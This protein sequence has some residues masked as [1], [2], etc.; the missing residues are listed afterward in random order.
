MQ[1]LRITDNGRQHSEISTHANDNKIVAATKYLLGINEFSQVMPTLKNRQWKQFGLNL[2][3]GGMKFGLSTISLATMTY[4]LGKSISSFVTSSNLKENEIDDL[5]RAVRRDSEQI[6]LKKERFVPELSKGSRKEDVN[7]KEKEWDDLMHPIE[8]DRDQ[9]KLKKERFV[10][11]LFKGSLKT[12]E[13]NNDLQNV[14][15]GLLGNFTMNST[16][17]NLFPQTQQDLPD[18]EKERNTKLKETKEILEKLQEKTKENKNRNFSEVLEEKLQTVKGER[19]A[20]ELKLESEFKQFLKDRVPEKMESYLKEITDDNIRQNL[21]EF[22]DV[23]NDQNDFDQKI[24][25]QL[26]SRKQQ[27]SY[28]FQYIEQVPEVFLDSMLKLIRIYDEAILEWGNHLSG[29]DSLS[30]LTTVKRKWI[31]QKFKAEKV[32]KHIKIANDQIRSNAQ[33]NTISKIKIVGAAIAVS[34]LSLSFYLSGCF[35]VH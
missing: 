7:I 15:H 12:E 13:N 21:R 10:S 25:S 6:K 34:C 19:E 8:R 14:K 16:I 5:I 27:E 33:Y 11:E 20:G 2:L 1:I 32:I 23:I 31:D 3:F 9:T 24:K 4:C 28:S 22:V 18:L 35:R 30:F 17:H 26:F 29:L